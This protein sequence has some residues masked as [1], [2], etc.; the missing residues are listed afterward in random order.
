MISTKQCHACK[1]Y[2]QPGIK[3]NDQHR[4]VETT[5]NSHSRKRNKRAH[6]NMKLRKASIEEKELQILERPL[7]QK[8]LGSQFKTR[9]HQSFSGYQN[10]E[11][12]T[13]HTNKKYHTQQNFFEPKKPNHQQSSFN[14]QHTTTSYHKYHHLE[15]SKHSNGIP[16][17]DMAVFDGILSEK[18]NKNNLIV[19]RKQQSTNETT[20]TLREQKQRENAA[21]TYYNI[22]M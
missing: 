13:T 1:I 10:G 9:N 12:T 21:N 19:R 3:I 15:T 18:N 20:E 2:L 14:P 7:P 6:T 5:D 4:C 11:T 17:K 16:N 8:E 22:L